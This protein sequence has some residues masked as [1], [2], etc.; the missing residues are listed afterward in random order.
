MSTKKLGVDRL[1]L[2]LGTLLGL[3]VFI[4]YFSVSWE[5]Y[6]HGPSSVGSSLGLAFLPFET[7]F[8]ALPTFIFGWSLGYIIRGML[9]KTL[10]LLPTLLSLVIIFGFA[11]YFILPIFSFIRA[12]QTVLELREMD[13]QALS[14]ATLYYQ[15][16]KRSKYTPFYFA[17]IVQNPKIN[18]QTLHQIALMQDP[19]L[20]EPM[21]S[22]WGLM[23]DNR[24]G[25]AVMRLIVKNPRV[26]V[27]TLEAL[28]ESGDGMVLDDIAISKNT[29][30]ELLTKIHEKSQGAY[31]LAYN[32]KTPPQILEDLAQKH[33]NNK[34]ILMK[35][36]ANQNAPQALRS[37]LKI[38]IQELDEK[39][40]L[41]F[42][43]QS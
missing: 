6:S 42:E 32:P 11:Y 22:P 28:I 2:I 9:L 33:S 15:R 36:E 38:K 4:I 3:L 13:G 12:Y 37:K 41:H 43:K 10:L 29:P 27:N 5:A 16:D 18:P 14:E 35:I 25:R 7:L 26:Q 30:V 17:A 40:R 24:R 39:D 19:F 21:W 20:Y 31:G 8:Y 34:Y 23:G 1:P